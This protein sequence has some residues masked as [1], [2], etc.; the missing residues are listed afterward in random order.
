MHNDWEKWH[1][2][3]Y[4]DY[5]ISQHW[6]C[7]VYQQRIFSSDL[8]TQAGVIKKA[9]SFFNNLSIR[10]KKDKDRKGYP[11]TMQPHLEKLEGM[12]REPSRIATE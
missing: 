12:H 4:A 11:V 7:R 9:I 5:L 6:K 3:T 10:Y 2:N 1:E 8:K